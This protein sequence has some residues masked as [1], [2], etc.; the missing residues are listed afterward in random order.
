MP[1]TVTTFLMFEGKA[2][3]ALEFYAGL[4]EGAQVT[5]LERYG[6]LGPAFPGSST[7][8]GPSQ[9]RPSC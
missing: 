4:F 9:W 5:Q 1:A 8:R 3:E 2:E 7:C 6:P